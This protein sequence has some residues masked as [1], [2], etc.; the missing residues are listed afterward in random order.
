[1]TERTEKFNK[2]YEDA[3]E[4]KAKVER[5]KAEKDAFEEEEAIQMSTM[6]LAKKLMEG[7]VNEPVRSHEQFM[8]D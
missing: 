4:R 7:R 8:E 3:F 2:L 1:M 6:P 5:A